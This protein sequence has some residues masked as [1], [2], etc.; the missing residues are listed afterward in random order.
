MAA[1]ISGIIA[2]TKKAGG[3]NNGE[4]WQRKSM[5]RRPYQWHVAEIS[6]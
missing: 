1:E 2:A 6:S 4:K 3:I 5:W